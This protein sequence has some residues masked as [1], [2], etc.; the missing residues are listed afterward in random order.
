MTLRDDSEHITSD[1]RT[2]GFNRQ[3]V[4][5][6][7]EQQSNSSSL[8]H[9]STFSHQ[10]PT[11]QQYNSKVHLLNFSGLLIAS[12]RRLKALEKRVSDLWMEMKFSYHEQKQEDLLLFVCWWWRRGH[13]MQF[14]LLLT[15]TSAGSSAH[16]SPAFFFFFSGFDMLD[17]RD[18]LIECSGGFGRRR[19]DA[20]RSSRTG[21]EI[22]VDAA[23]WRGVRLH[24]TTKRRDRTATTCELRV[25]WQRQ[26]SSL[27]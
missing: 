25:T 4:G 22:Q 23:G 9:T 16:S 11:I 10:E 2:F 21:S 15:V 18:S 24:V 20:G 5:Q 17:G 8:H 12:H 26:L 14:V 13:M 1:S 6:P 27:W 19:G 7:D 3:H